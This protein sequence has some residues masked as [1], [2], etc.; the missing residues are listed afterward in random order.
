MATHFRHLTL[1]C[2]VRPNF[3]HIPAQQIHK[4]TLE[5]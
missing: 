1:H 3:S 4:F 2:D 5:Q